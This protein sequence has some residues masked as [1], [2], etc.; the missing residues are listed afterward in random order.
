MPLDLRPL[1]QHA[2]RQQRIQ[3]QW[4]FQCICTHC[5][6]SHGQTALSDSRLELIV[7]LEEELLN[8]SA[9]RTA[10]PDTAELLVD[11]YLQERLDG[12]V[13]DA[14]AYAALEYAYIGEKRQAQK[15]AAK[16]IEAL[17]LW[18]GEDHM[19]YQ[20]MWSL[21]VD[22]EGHDSWRYMVKGERKDSTSSFHEVTAQFVVSGGD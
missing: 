5:S 12:A 6:L 16:S 19:Y 14:Y 8:L 18:R 4:G 11:L 17:A 3:E 9:N 20:G 1:V 2:E 22:P 7:A 21:L 10:T 15:W 13:A